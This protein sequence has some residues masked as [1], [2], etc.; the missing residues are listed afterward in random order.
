MANKKTKKKTE[1]EEKTEK[2]ELT[3]EEKHEKFVKL[4]L[5]GEYSTTARSIKANVFTDVFERKEYALKL[6][7]VFHPEL[8]DIKIEDIDIITLKIALMNAPYNDLGLLVKDKIV[9]L[10]EAQSTWSDNILIRILIY[11]AYTY[12]NYILAHG[13]DV[14]QKN[15]IQLPKPEFYVVYT[16]DEE[17]PKEIKFSEKFFG[18]ADIDIEIKAT[19]ITESEKGNVL[20]QYIE[21]AHTF[22]RNRETFGRVREAARAT[23]EHCLENGILVDY[24]KEKGI[25][26]VIGLMEFIFDQETIMRNHDLSLV[27]NTERRMFVEA[28]QKFGHT[29][30]ETIKAFVEQFHV[31]K[32]VAEKDIKEYWKK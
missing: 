4:M 23:V 29:L 28:A 12:K 7:K 11:L 14:Y 20:D 1:Q 15:A 24:I 6:V 18:G 9:I 22:D 8:S 30:A 26:E 3:E 21:F 31:D 27:R 16:G 2:K 17:H 13:L 25:E 32:E 10:V 19:V 5:E